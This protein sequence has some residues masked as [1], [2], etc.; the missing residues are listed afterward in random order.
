[1]VFGFRFPG[2]SHFLETN[3]SCS[4][5]IWSRAYQSTYVC[6]LKIDCWNTKNPQ[7][8]S[9]FP[10][11]WEIFCV[12]IL[13]IYSLLDLSLAKLWLVGSSTQA[14]VVY[15]ELS[16]AGWRLSSFWK[17]KKLWKD[18]C[19]ASRNASLL[20]LITAVAGIGGSPVYLELEDKKLV[21]GLESRAWCGTELRDGLTPLALGT[22]SLHLIKVFSC[23]VLALLPDFDGSVGPVG[24]IVGCKQPKHHSANVWPISRRKISWLSS[25]ENF[26]LFICNN[27]IVETRSH[28]IYSHLTAP[29]S[30]LPGQ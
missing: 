14:G 8:V 4:R 6:V 22:Y 30:C 28:A 5:L 20:L 29:C 27:K 16:K 18:V 11:S 10:F 25:L 13:H 2:I 15:E 26:F 23:C 17:W 3:S 9:K 1:M 24:A 21:K 12:P 19:G 7:A